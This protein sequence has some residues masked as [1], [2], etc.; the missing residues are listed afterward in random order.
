MEWLFDKLGDFAAPY[1]YFGAHP[2]GGADYGFWLSE[3]F[4]YFYEG[5]QVEDLSEVP[6][7]YRGEVLYVN[8]HGNMTLYIK[9]SRGFKEIWGIV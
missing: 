7:E 5:L 1:F 8:D 6:K 3:D 2:G 9:N 4:E